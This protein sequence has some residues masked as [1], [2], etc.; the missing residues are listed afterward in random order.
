MVTLKQQIRFSM[1]FAP[2]LLLI[3]PLQVVTQDIT[4]TTFVAFCMLGMVA[5]LLLYPTN[6]KNEIF[7]RLSSLSLYSAALGY[8]AQMNQYELYKLQHVTW[9]IVVSLAILTVWQLDVP[10]DAAQPR[11]FRFVG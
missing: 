10:A 7:V 4:T 5:T 3:L 9:L 8:V 11:A 6:I 2:L 1:R